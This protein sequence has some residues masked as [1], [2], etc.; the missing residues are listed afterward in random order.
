NDSIGG[1]NV[2]SLASQGTHR[3][4]TIAG[5]I[6]APEGRFDKDVFVLGTLNAGNMVELGTRLPSTSTLSPLVTLLRADGTVIADEDGNAADGH[7]MATLSTDGQYYAQITGGLVFGGHQYLLTDAGMNWTAAEAYAQSLGGHLV[8]IDDAAE[9]QWVMQ[10]FGWSNP[11]IGLSD[12]AVEG[13]WVWSNG[14]STGYS[15]WASGHPYSNYTNYNHAYMSSDGQWYNG[16]YGWGNR[17]LIELDGA[18]QGTKGSGPE[19]KYLLDVKVSDQVPPRVEAVSLPL[20]L[21]IV[22]APVGPSFSVTL[23]ERLDGATVAAGN[24]VVWQHGDHFYKLTDAS[25]NWAQAEAEAQ[26][27]GGHL[28]QIDDAAEQQW[29]NQ[30]LDGRYGSVWIGLTDQVA[31]GTWV[32]S[33][34][35]LPVYTNWGSGEPFSGWNGYDYGYDYGYMR[36]DGQWSA[37]TD[38]NLRG[39]IEFTAT[40]SDG[41][42]LPDSMDPYP[43]DKNN[44]WDLREAGVDGVFDTAD[45]VIHRLVLDG[46][47][48][49]G[50]L[51][52]LKI[53]DGSLGAGHYRFT[54]NATL[55][56]VVG[57]ALDGNGDGSGG[58]AYHRYFTIDIP[59]SVHFETQHNN[60]TT[61]ATVMSLSEEPAGSGLLLGYGAGYQAGVVYGSWNDPDYWRVELQAG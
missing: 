45:D 42:G 10:N 20:E 16:N 22:H 24:V 21:A 28:V 55:Q 25:E 47:Y 52:N 38:T 51:V 48:T 37:T 34:G 36:S 33:S 43:Q 56:D 3:L 53:E 32:S 4:V 44:A 30:T 60:T 1:A 9:Q 7:F 41:D 12:Q 50:T 19:A 61:N 46:A 40:D 58:D 23:S 14:A 18:G 29:V 31:E 13:A 57:N 27:L 35:A 59:D 11:W 2:L 15:N 26:A 8:T 49:A 17:G 5:T 6:M 39:L 54:A